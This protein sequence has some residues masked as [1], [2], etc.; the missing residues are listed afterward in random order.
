LFNKSLLLYFFR[1]NNT[2]CKCAIRDILR[3]NFKGTWHSW[4]KVD[5]MCRDELFKE[6]K[7][8]TNTSHILFNFNNF[9]LAL[10]KFSTE[11]LLFFIIVCCLIASFR[12]MILYTKNLSNMNLLNVSQVLELTLILVNGFTISSM[13]AYGLFMTYS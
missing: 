11:V 12:F 10:W 1:F 2:S 6:F 8:S 4:E 13:R 3:F 5:L 7:V 9:N